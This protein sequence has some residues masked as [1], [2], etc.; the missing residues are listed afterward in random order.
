MCPQG[1]DEGLQWEFLFILSVVLATN[2]DG[3]HYPRPTDARLWPLPGTLILGSSR[4][5][6]PLADTAVVRHL[7]S[8]LLDFPSHALSAPVSSLEGVSVLIVFLL[9]PQAEHNVSHM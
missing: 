8:A 3:R 1:D 6:L 7:S 9:Y 2:G 4:G 5:G